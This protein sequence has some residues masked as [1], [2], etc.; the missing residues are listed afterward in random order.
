MELR[1]RNVGYG[2]HEY[3]CAFCELIVAAQDLR[4]ARHDAEDESRAWLGYGKCRGIDV[5]TSRKI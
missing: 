4:N 2:F 1:C 5:M 3:V